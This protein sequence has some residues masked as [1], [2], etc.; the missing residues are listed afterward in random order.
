MLSFIK[1]NYS[2]KTKYRFQKIFKFNKL[3][4]LILLLTCSLLTSVLSSRHDKIAAE[5]SHTYIKDDNSCVI[6]VT[7]G[8]NSRNWCLIAAMAAWT[9]NVEQFN[10]VKTPRLTFLCLIESD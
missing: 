5:Y 10:K 7:Q 4:I 9:S 6:T 3:K 2:L 8:N 1:K